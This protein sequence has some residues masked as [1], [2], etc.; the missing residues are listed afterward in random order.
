[1]DVELLAIRYSGV[2][3]LVFTVHTLLHSRSGER[4]QCTQ[5][6]GVETPDPMY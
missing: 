2:Y 1:M 3:V 6:A 4:L 5:A